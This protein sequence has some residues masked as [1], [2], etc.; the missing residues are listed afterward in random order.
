VHPVD[1]HR[2]PHGQNPLAMLVRQFDRDRP[3]LT[4]GQPVPAKIGR[5][6]GPR[7]FGA[8]QA[9]ELKASIVGCETRALSHIEMEARHSDL[10]D[11]TGYLPNSGESTL[12]VDP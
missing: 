12:F 8:I 2:H 10:S 3:A 6:L 5:Q 1:L 4:L 11:L 9:V 7:A